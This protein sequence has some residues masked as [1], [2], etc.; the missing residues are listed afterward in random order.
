[1]R[2]AAS[3]ADL[4]FGQNRAV[5]KR[6]RR[7]L[8][9]LREAQRAVLKPLSTWA[10]SVSQLYTNPYSPLAYT[11]FANRVSAGLELLHRLGKE[12]EKPE[13]NIDETLIDDHPVSVVERIELSLIHI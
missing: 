2:D 12:Y 13:F 10:D 4:K 6:E 9:H 1:M 3:D 7:M 5:L 8:Y 11:P